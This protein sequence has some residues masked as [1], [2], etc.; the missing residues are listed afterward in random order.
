MAESTTTLIYSVRWRVIGKYL[1]QLSLMLA[2]VTLVPLAVSLYFHEYHISLRYL[3]VVGILLAMFMPSHYLPV[4]ERIQSNEALVIVALMFVL[5]AVLMAYPTMGA[6]V[7]VMDALFE[8]ISGVTTTGLS[9]LPTVED[10]PA[11]FLFA[12]AWMQWYGGLG[13]VVLSV[14]LLMGHQAAV[15][16]LTES[17]AGSDFDTTA[18]V[19]AR[20]MLAVYVALTLAG[21]ALLWLFGGNGFEALTHTLSAVST[22]GF[23][24][25]DAS[26]AAF[27]WPMRF[28][29]IALTV[30]G[31]LPFPL[32]YLLYKR[33][34]RSVF[35][36]V[37]FKALIGACVVVA[38]LLALLLYFETG[39]PMSDSLA[40]GVLLGASAQTTAGFTSYPIHEL[41]P[42]AKL[43]MIVS[44]LSGGGIG[45]TAGG[46]KL[47]RLLVL[48]RL[49]QMLLQ[50]HAMPKHAVVKPR[51]AAR[52][53]EP[54]DIQQMALLF[55]LF[56]IV[57]IVSWVLFVFHGYP[58][59][60]A[61]F[62]VVSATGTVGLSTGI[63]RQALEPLLK[64]VLCIDM[65]LGRVEIIAFLVLFYPRTWFGKRTEG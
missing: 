15:K 24:T 64:A 32:Y 9:T 23:A 33:Q 53:L 25:H 4:P 46:I 2:L 17:A 26:L 6:H 63:T 28:A 27:A 41:G 49:I 21:I 59:I 29:V 10:K 48:F 38:A 57:V 54:E 36:D 7:S 45:S 51:F 18:R 39:L 19:Y 11:S 31:A 35:T 61:L 44:M 56:V 8:S 22:G 43:I 13:I 50:R 40:H 3:L 60:D 52:V 12:R 14:G 62:E 16:R 37:E 5:S 30:C 58:P 34:W 55:L 65:L 1:G 47:L 20:R 42:T